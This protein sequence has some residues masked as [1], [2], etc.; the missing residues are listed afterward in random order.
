[1]F[2]SAGS[3][4][5]GPTA[6]AAAGARHVSGVGV[7]FLCRDFA[8]GGFG[9][10]G[11]LEGWS[12]KK[13]WQAA[14]QLRR[15]ERLSSPGSRVSRPEPK[16][17]RRLRQTEGGGGSRGVSK[18]LAMHCRHSVEV[19]PVTVGG[20]GIVGPLEAASQGAIWICTSIQG[21]GR[22]D[23]GAWGESRRRLD[24]E[25]YSR[26]PAVRVLDL[27][28]LELGRDLG[29]R[30]R[31]VWNRW[32]GWLHEACTVFPGGPNSIEAGLGRL[33]PRVDVCFSTCDSTVDPWWQRRRLRWGGGV[34]GS[35]D[36]D[37]ESMTEMAVQGRQGAVEGEAEEQ[38]NCSA[39]W[40]AVA[41]LVPWQQDGRG[42]WRV[43]PGGFILD[44][45]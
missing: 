6:G 15:N 22:G 31:M 30:R 45:T 25:A 37:D 12:P 28:C 29:V 27:D 33:R 7:G 35:S 41:C 39:G 17:K 1:M 43:D 16:S 40:R 13:M 23:N 18:R 42:T 3:G 5:H 38:R 36:A 14:Q 8:I 20:V 11:S 4:L 2:A 44:P 24:V 21:D 19:G 26:R 32:S 10:S 34:A 9:W